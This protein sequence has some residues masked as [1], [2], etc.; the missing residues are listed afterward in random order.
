MPACDG[1]ERERPRAACAPSSVL[2]KRPD[3]KVIHA[4]RSNCPARPLGSR[5]A[6]ASTM[7]PGPVPRSRRGRHFWASLCALLRAQPRAAPSQPAT[8]K[9]E[10]AGG[11][12]GRRPGGPGLVVVAEED[13]RGA[14]RRGG[15]GGGDGGEGAEVL[16]RGAVVR[17][18][19]DDDPRGV[20]LRGEEGRRRRGRSEAVVGGGKR[21]ENAV[22]LAAHCAVTASAA[23]ARVGSGA[24]GGPAAGV[25]R[26]RGG[27]G[28]PCAAGWS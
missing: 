26:W 11:R 27:T 13:P 23:C 28:R 10:R 4:A 14:A 15:G 20:G 16:G 1:A 17:A 6:A 8:P 22:H 18:D 3:D 19:G 21:K 25:S 7:A 9:A 5:S 12:P 2:Q 24:R